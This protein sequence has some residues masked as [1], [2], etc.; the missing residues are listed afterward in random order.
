MISMI[1]VPI[2]SLLTKLCSLFFA[3]LVTFETF[4]CTFLVPQNCVYT[5][6]QFYFE[7]IELL[8]IRAASEPENAPRFLI[9]EESTRTRLIA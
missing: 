6:K 5:Q 3:V 1:V 7:N 4:Q 9:L 8:F 2:S